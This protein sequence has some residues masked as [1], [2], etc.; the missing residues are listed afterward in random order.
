MYARIL[1]IAL[2]ALL[3]LAGCR[4]WESPAVKLTPCPSCGAAAKYAHSGESW[5]CI[6]TR[7]PRACRAWETSKVRAAERWKQETEAK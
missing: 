6:C 1:T 4:E 7:C 5:L 3:L 2:I